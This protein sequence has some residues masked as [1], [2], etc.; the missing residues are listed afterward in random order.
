MS[1]TGSSG[2]YEGRLVN[3]SA[4]RHAHRVDLHQ[5]IRQ[6]NGYRS[7]WLMAKGFARRASFRKEV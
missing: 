3:F 1:E 5:S 6:F 2:Q 7:L 4:G